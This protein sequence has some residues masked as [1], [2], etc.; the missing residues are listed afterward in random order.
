VRPFRA[1]SLSKGLPALLLIMV[2]ATGCSTDAA[3]QQSQTGSENGYVGA[4]RQLTRVAP[5]QRKP[6]PRISGPSVTGPE[7]VDSADYD[8]K[9]LVVNVWGSWCPPCRKEAPDLQAASERTSE[10]AQFIGIDSRDASKAQP[11]AF[12]RTQGISYPSI[13]DPDGTQVVKFS[14]LPPSAIPS[15]LI[16]DEQGGIAVRILGTI[17][18]QT[19]VDMVNDV[20]AGK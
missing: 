12:M 18:E 8:G 14:D 11:Q 7:T 15:T 17:S 10:V 2:V 20:A 9:V 16:I 3:G 6:A 19:L 5:D 4:D 13:F 1:L